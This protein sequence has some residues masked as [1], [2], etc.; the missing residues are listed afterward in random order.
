LR[1]AIEL[2]EDEFL[3]VEVAAEEASV[4]VFSN[5]SFTLT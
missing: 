2:V 4:F 5:N 1:E 3:L